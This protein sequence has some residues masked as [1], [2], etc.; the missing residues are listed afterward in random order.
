MK[1][2]SV[3]AF[4]STLFGGNPAGVVVVPADG[5]FPSDEFMRRVAAE[6]KH[7]ET[8]FVKP[9]GNARFHARYFTPVAE[10]PLCGHAT[11]AAA[12]AL[13]AFGYV[14]AH[15]ALVFDTGAGEMRIDVADGVIMMDMA[16]P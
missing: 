2:Q 13:A 3:N 5:A 4:S 6:L 10:V 14:G 1:L 8:A 16:P 9:M 11:I 7:S 15:Q 12:H